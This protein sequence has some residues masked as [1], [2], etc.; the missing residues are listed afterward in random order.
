MLKKY[1]FRIWGVYR[2]L[3]GIILLIMLYTG[4]LNG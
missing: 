1:G 2:V 3:V 4:Y